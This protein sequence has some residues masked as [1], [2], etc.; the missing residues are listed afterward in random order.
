MFA[1]RWGAFPT[2]FGLWF[3]F[4]ALLMPHAGAQTKP[5]NPSWRVEWDR[6]VE[7][8]KKEGKV[9]IFGPPGSNARQALADSFQNTFP[10]IKVEY[11]G[12]T[13]AKTA[14]RILSE[15]RAGIHAVDIH[16][17]GTTTM[18]ES[19]LPAKVLDAIPPNLILP[20]VLDSSKWLQGKLDYSDS[21]GRYNLVFT[22]AVKVPAAVN[23]QMVKLEEIRSYWDLLSSKW[24]G[25]IAMRDPTGAG[26]GLATATFWYAHPG[27]GVKFMRDLFNKQQLTLS[28]DDRQLLEW[29]VRGRY[30]MVISPSELEANGLKAKGVS[31]EMM[32]A[33]KFKEGSYLTAAFGSV[34][35]IARAPHP[36]AAKVYLNWL[37][38]RDGQTQWTKLSG[39]PS[40]RLD[41]PRDHLNPMLVPDE[42]VEYQ[43]NYKEEFVRLKGDILKL[44]TELVK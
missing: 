37:L 43:A 32:G 5:G 36:N 24:S 19:L 21:V 16:V 29:V 14:P 17:G 34:A 33:E 31:I 12:A 35:L 20:E 1:R 2:S 11:Q 28:R 7:A 39:Y 42:R 27:L 4:L 41:V 23:P 44:L 3:L 9:I 40:R 26:P 8:A 25:K 18:L 38:T 13:G 22:A 15:Q 30:A 6:L 10:E